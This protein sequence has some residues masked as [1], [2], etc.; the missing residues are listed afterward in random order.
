LFAGSVQW[1]LCL[2]YLSFSMLRTII[3]ILQGVKL[4]SFSVVGVWY[5]PMWNDLMQGRS[6]FWIQI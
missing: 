5:W 3:L 2:M 6:I 1:P 4:N